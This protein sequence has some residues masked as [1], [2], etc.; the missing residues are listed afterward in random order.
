MAIKEAKK[1]FIPVYNFNLESGRLEPTSTLNAEN[2]VGKSEET[3]VE[4]WDCLKNM[5][6]RDKEE[7]ILVEE[8]AVKTKN[9]CKYN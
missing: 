2:V 4:L 5:T 7:T 1:R 3:L 9:S 8:A 6:Q